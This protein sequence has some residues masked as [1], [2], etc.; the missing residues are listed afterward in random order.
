MCLKHVLKPR[1]NELLLCPLE[2]LLHSTLGGRW[3]RSRMRLVGLTRN[4]A[5][6]QRIG[7]AF[8]R[9]KRRVKL[10]SLQKALGLML[11]LFAP[12]SYWAH[13]CSPP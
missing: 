7:I 3:V 13:F 1:L 4:T 9:Q 8:Q 11:S 12:L 2:V 10:L 5:Q 6:Q